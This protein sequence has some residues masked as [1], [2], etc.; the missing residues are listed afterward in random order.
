MN[1]NIS[2]AIL[3]KCDEAMGRTKI[4]IELTRKQYS[5]LYT[6]LVY[7]KGGLEDIQANEESAERYGRER[8]EKDAFD[9]LELKSILRLSERRE[10]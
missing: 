10:I 6:A 1:K 4:T 7:R 3:N 5:A 8:A 2:Q 9:I